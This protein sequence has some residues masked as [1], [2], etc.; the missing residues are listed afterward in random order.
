MDFFRSR[1]RSRERGGP[2]PAPP[3]LWSRYDMDA[4]GG[5]HLVELT[6]GGGGG[7]L[8]PHGELWSGGAEMRWDQQ[9]R[10]AQEQA[11]T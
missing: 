5:A 9:W 8:T 6:S 11:Q 4:W 3:S 7:D 10:Q 2:A 1:S